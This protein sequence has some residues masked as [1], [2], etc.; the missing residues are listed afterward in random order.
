MKILW[1]ALFALLA[2]VSSV[3]LQIPRHHFSSSPFTMRLPCLLADFVIGVDWDVWNQKSDEGYGLI[4]FVISINFSTRLLWS[5]RHKKSLQIILKFT[6]GYAKSI[7]KLDKSNVG[8]IACAKLQSHRQANFIPFF[9]PQALLSVGTL[10]NFSLHLPCNWLYEA[11]KKSFQE[12][13]TAGFQW[14]FY[15]ARLLFQWQVYLIVN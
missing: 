3:I 13:K 11:K 7:R 10:F 12:A 9:P 4:P 8:S 15:A 1:K 6:C 5:L 14:A 2:T